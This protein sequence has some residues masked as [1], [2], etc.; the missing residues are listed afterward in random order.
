M[1]DG[2]YSVIVN[3]LYTVNVGADFLLELSIVRG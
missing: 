2:N 3:F 1:K